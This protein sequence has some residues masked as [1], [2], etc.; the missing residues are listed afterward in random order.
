MSTATAALAVFGIFAGFT[1]SYGELPQ[2]IRDDFESADPPVTPEQFHDAMRVIGYSSM[3]AIALCAVGVVLAVL[4]LRGNN[5]A[6]TGLIVISVLVA[7]MALLRIGALVPVVW[8]IT[9]VLVASLLLSKSAK[10][11]FLGDRT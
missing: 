6:R 5:K 9:G 8:L 1:V 4:V 10:A 7:A 11:W 3:V 2:S